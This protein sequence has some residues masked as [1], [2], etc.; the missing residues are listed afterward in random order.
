MDQISTNPAVNNAQVVRP[1][2]EINERE[3]VARLAAEVK[4]GGL[5]VEI[6][7]LYGGMTAVMGL[8]NPKAEIISIDDFS[9]HPNDDVPTSPELLMAN[10]GRVGVTNVQVITGDSREIG[11]I[12]DKQ[13]DFL[14]VDGGHS[15]DYIYKDLCNFGPFAQV[16]AAHDYGN[17]YWPSIQEAVEKFVS[18]NNV[19]EISEVAGT[20]VVLRRVNQ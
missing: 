9:W 18:E 15:F 17:P 5:M 20:V 4:A 3:C 10:M 13:I 16:I 7:C 11:K 19:W 8:A 6:G 2:T 14:W 12:W 1:L